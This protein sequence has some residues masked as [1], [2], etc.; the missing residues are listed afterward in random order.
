MLEDD[1]YGAQ[2]LAGILLAILGMIGLSRALQAL[3]YG[4]PLSGWVRGNLT[5]LDPRQAALGFTLL[6]SGGVYLAID[7][8]RKRRRR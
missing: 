7:A 2:L 1:G 3:A 5:W 8:W 6:L 4:T